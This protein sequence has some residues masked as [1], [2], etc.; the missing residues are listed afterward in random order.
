LTQNTDVL[1]VGA[2]PTG[3][4]L[5][6]WLTRLGIRVRI[7]DKVPEPGTTSRALAVQARTLELYR[8]VGLADA[9]LSRGR[10][11]TTINLWKRG[12]HVAHVVFGD[13]GRD[14]SPF[15]YALIYPQDEH[16]RLLIDR[17]AEAGVQVER[18]MELV[19]FE[20]TATGVRA[21]L[22]CAD[23]GTNTCE[24]A[25]LAGCDGAH[26]AVREGLRIGFPGGTYNHLF[27]VAD[28]DARGAVM[29]GELHGALDTTDFLIVF[30]L[31]DDGRARLIGTVRTDAEQAGDDLSW[32]DVSRR[33]IEWIRIDVQ[34]VHW[35]STYR[36]HHRVADRFRNGRTFLLGDAAHIHSPVGGQGMNTGI[37][38]AVNLAWKIADVMHSRAD[39]ALLDSY[40]PERIAF[41]RRLVAST[42]R[43]FI[44]VTSDLGIAR[45]VRL[46]VVPA[47]APA[48][49]SFRAARRFMFRTI[50][51]ISVHYRDSSLSE[52]R[53][54]DVHGGD[55]LPWVPPDQNGV[56][57]FTALTS[58]GWQVHVYGDATRSIQTACDER[59]LPLHL[60]PWR[61]AMGRAGLRRNALYVVRPDGYVA[62][63]DAG[64]SGAAIA[65]Y[66]RSRKFTATASGRT[67]R[68]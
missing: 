34:R 54:G 63:A 61:P 3:L 33:I 42:D 50:S 9:V 2:G 10:K 12:Q 24:T 14:L 16:E 13:M 7:I 52:G 53:A 66:F 58:L 26:S 6:L 56:D 44:G 11:M 40:E 23:G 8:Q 67:I 27:Y 29:N 21:S 36:V 22:K 19:A 39:A 31:K 41:A 47:V 18:Q 64:G 43:A 55:R 17:L 4:V 32:D 25:Y 37:G 20:E 35:F 62:L 28:V 49:F 38:D 59:E 45:W 65:S 30:P 68:S 57:N 48:V 51:Q 1:I 46:N 5:A 15:P 60:F